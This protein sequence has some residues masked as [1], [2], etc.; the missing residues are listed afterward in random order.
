MFNQFRNQNGEEDHYHILGL[1]RDATLSQIKKA[2]HKLALIHHPDKNNGDAVQFNKINSAYQVLSDPNKKKMYDSIGFCNNMSGDFEGLFTTASKFSNLFNEAGNLGSLFNQPTKHLKHNFECTLEELFFGSMKTINLTRNIQT[3]K[4]GPISKEKKS[5]DLQIKPGWKEGTKVTYHEHGNILYG[6]KPQDL[7]I[8]IKEK[9]H[10]QFK[11]CGDDLY[12]QIQ[13]TLKE[14]LVGFEREFLNLDNQL[15]NF[16]TNEMTTPEKYYFIEGKG[17]PNLKKGKR[18]ILNIQCKIIYPEK[19][20][21][22]QKKK[23]QEILS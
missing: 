3:T 8:T 9:K 4:N 2:Y 10:P 17:M 14:S 20:T 11:R 18:G 16:K 23:I 7:I 22:L 19:L 1:E 12:T 21:D 15:V 6:K 5:I 13:I